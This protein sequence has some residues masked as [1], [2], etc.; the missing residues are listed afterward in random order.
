MEIKTKSGFVCD[1]N[2]KKIKDWRFIKLVGKADTDNEI[3]GMKASTEI[4]SFLL[5]KKDEERLYKHVEK[6]G[7]AAYEDVLLEIKD[8]LKFCGEAEQKKFSSLP[9]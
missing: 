4:L 2:T 7:V 6:D 1:V 9:E 5:S 3:E 8:I